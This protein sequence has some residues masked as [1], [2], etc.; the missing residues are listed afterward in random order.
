MC[1]CWGS[2]AVSSRS[3]EF[4]SCPG[5]VDPNSRFDC[6]TYLKSC[7]WIPGLGLLII[8][9]NISAPRI[10]FVSNKGTAADPIWGGGG[11]KEPEAFAEIVPQVGYPLLAEQTQQMRQEDKLCMFDS[12][13]GKT[14]CKPRAAIWEASPVSILNAFIDSCEHRPHI[15]A[16]QQLLS[17]KAQLWPR[18]R[19]RRCPAAPGPLPAYVSTL[20]NHWPRSGSP[21]TIRDVGKLFPGEQQPFQSSGQ[22]GKADAPGESTGRT[23]QLPD[24]GKMSSPLWA[25]LWR[26]R[27]WDFK[28]GGAGEKE[29]K[30]KKNSQLEG[31]NL[32]LHTEDRYCCGMEDAGKHQER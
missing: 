3:T 30:M 16:G 15:L 12:G 13:T 27:E 7:I 4:H 9:C 19:C 31:C 1:Q 22:G 24:E 5:K 18:P 23:F 26:L 32:D 25:F 2:Q 28:I 20:G 8:C 6:L 17:P 29:G 11:E 21:L 10:Y 14:S